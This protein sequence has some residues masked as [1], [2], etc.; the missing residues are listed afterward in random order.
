MC[1]DNKNI[2]SCRCAACNKELKCDEFVFC[3]ECEH[4]SLAEE[5]IISFLDEYLLMINNQFNIV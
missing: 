4:M 5:D 2:G 3:S 1:M